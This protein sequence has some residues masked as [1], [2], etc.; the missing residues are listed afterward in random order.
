MARGQSRSEATVIDADDSTRTRI[1]QAALR[2]FIHLGMAKTSLQDVAE[3]AEVS[4]GTVYRYF[5]DRQTLIDEVMS[6]GWERYFADAAD[7]MG[8][9][10]TLATQAG[11]FAASVASILLE[12]H[13]VIGKGTTDTVLMKSILAD[14]AE[15]LR[16]TVTFLRPYVTS[17]ID[18]GEVEPTVD[19]DEACE[20]LGRI[21]MSV[22]T[23]PSSTSFDIDDPRSVARFVERYAVAGLG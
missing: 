19:V 6:M 16:R 22:T 9:K 17:A 23:S 3:S 8:K 14:S 10:R 21:I 4:R 15:T 18:R 7:A 13:A 2:C 5:S 11:A 1:L 20:W 12:H